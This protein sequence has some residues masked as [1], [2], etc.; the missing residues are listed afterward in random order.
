MKTI[1]LIVAA[2][3]I[4]SANQWEQKLLS[5]NPENLQ[6]FEEF[7]TKYNKMYGSYEDMYARFQVFEDNLKTIEWINAMDKGAVHGI[8]QFTDLSPEEFKATYLTLK[9]KEPTK[10][11]TTNPPTTETSWDWRDHGAMTGVK[12]QGQCGS[13]WAF[14]AIANIEGQYFLGGKTLTPFSEQELVDCDTVDQGCNGGLMEDAFKQLEVIGG[15][16]TE[17]AYPYEGVGDKCAYDQTKEVVEIK[18]YHFISEDETVIAG[19]VVDQGPMAIAINASFFQFYLGGILDF[20][21]CNK[22]SLNHGVTLAGFGTGK[23][24]FGKKKDYWLIKNS[25]GPTWGEKGY[26]RVR[27]GTGYCGVNTYVITAEL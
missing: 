27:R 4:V 25:W 7:M 15:V 13:C 8:S 16:E 20:P 24:L 6:K 22:K 19:A 9:H 11:R 5:S 18:G 26:I 21:L 12:N 10:E 23:T 17:S 3:A 1:I 14:S 2:L